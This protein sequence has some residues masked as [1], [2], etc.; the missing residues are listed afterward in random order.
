MGAGKLSIVG[1]PL[2]NRADLSERARATLQAADAILCEDTR[3]SAKLVSGLCPGTPLERADERTLAARADGIVQRLLAGARLA[4]VSDAGMP[5]I[6]DPGGVLVDAAL[7]A[8][9]EVEVVPG[10][11]AVSCAIAASGLACP[12]FLFQGFLPRKG[13]GRARA[14]GLIASLPAA[15]VVYESPHRV[16]RTL[17]DVAAVLPTRRMALCRE[18]TKLHEEVLRGTAAELRALLDRREAEGRPLKGECVIVVEA[19]TAR[20]EGE[21]EE[22]DGRAVEDLARQRL[23]EGLSPSAAARAVARDAGISRS[24][25]YG[26]VLRVSR[27]EA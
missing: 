24:D 3:V 21:R 2:G 11:S 7:E 20:E 8:G 25:A 4:F 1:T 18:L 17:D 13:S 9:V 6:S 26:A 27:S 22:R 10:P 15:T 16:G 5:C 14:L 23:G 19:P 12:R